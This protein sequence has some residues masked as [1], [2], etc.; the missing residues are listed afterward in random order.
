MEISEKFLDLCQR[1]GEKKRSD[2]TLIM[3]FLPKRKKKIRKAFVCGP[4]RSQWDLL[5]LG[6]MMIGFHFSSSV[7][8]CYISGSHNNAC[9]A[10]S[11]IICEQG[12]SSFDRL[13]NGKSSVL[14]LGR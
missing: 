14:Y 1:D 7:R 12:T 8:Y 6:M 3:L 4:N 9:V 2:E 13:L 11:E 10:R 5:V